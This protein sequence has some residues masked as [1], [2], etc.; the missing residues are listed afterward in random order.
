MHINKLSDGEFLL[1]VSVNGKQIEM[2]YDTAAVCTVINKDIWHSIGSP[3][4]SPMSKLVAYS[5][6]PV[7]MLG[8]ANVK[9]SLVNMTKKKFDPLFG[10]DWMKASSVR[11]HE[12]HTLGLS[13][14]SNSRAGHGAVVKSVGSSPDT[15]ANKAITQIL[16]LHTEI[17]DG[18][19]SKIKGHQA[20]VHLCE[21]V[22]PV[23][24]RARLV[25]FALRSGVDTEL[26][27]LVGE[28][29]LEPINPATMPIEWAS[30]TVNIPKP[31]GAVARS[32]CADFSVL[33]NK[34]VIVDRHPL[35]RFEEITSKLAGGQEF[36]KIDLRDAFLQVEVHPGLHKYLVIA[37]HKGYFR[38][39]RLPFGLSSL[40]SV[41]QRIMDTILADLKGVVY[42]IDDILITAKTC[43]EHLK[44]LAQVFDRL[45]AC[46]V[47]TQYDKCSFLQKSVTYLGHK[48]D[49]T[50]IHPTEKRIEAI[51][52]APS[53]TTV[54]F[55]L[56]D[57][58]TTD[59][60]SD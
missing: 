57:L 16:N 36:S 30:P 19:L 59:P 41:F 18:K 8:Q 12:I 15:V 34:H 54:T 3:K 1:N 48:I 49:H 52:D 43:E 6:T 42:F 46:G 11:P 45:Q 14:K 4:L 44:R 22:Q 51:R 40:P 10:V 38:Y 25:E 33:I 29:I 5:E 17:L 20:V 55:F 58:S 53:L 60:F 32:I 47:R 26:D 27:R 31:Y 23:V 50:G 39:K 37:T 28:D 35:L 13:F 24:H 2:Q 7:F 9:V 56:G 21:R